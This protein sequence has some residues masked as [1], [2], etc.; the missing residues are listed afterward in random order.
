MPAAGCAELGP[1]AG[2]PRPG[3]CCPPGRAR[4]SQIVVYRR[5][6]EIR[7]AKT[8]VEDRAA[9]VHEILIEQVAD[10]LGLFA[11]R[12]RPHT[13]TDPASVPLPLVLRHQAR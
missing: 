10:L 7:G 6:V 1:A 2:V 3:Q 8:L 12:H 11:G 9:L 5:P 13:R 4:K